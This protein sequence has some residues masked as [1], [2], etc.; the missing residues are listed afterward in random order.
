MARPR[1]DPH[2]RRTAS[3]RSDLT[4]AEKCYVQE[5]A[6]RAGLSEAEYTRRRVLDYAVR[7]A[8]AGTRVDPALVSEINRLGQEVNALGNVV[9]QVALYCHT[10][11]GLRDDWADLPVFIRDLRRSIE[12]AVERL[13]LGND[14]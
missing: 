2:E 3:V 4:L 9:N 13:V 7:A 5:Q 1:K 6:S 8:S 10:G 14:P 12:A 11:R